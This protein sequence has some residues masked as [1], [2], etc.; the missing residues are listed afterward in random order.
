[1]L[2]DERQLHASGDTA[3]VTNFGVQRN[4]ESLGPL[5]PAWTLGTL[6]S[7]GARKAGRAGGSLRALRPDDV[8]L[9][10]LLARATRFIGGNETDQ[11][12]LV[13]VAIKSEAGVNDVVRRNLG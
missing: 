7:L 4:A 3:R 6:R 5:R 1:L 13:S 9:D 10:A 11:P 12:A 8:P 2:V